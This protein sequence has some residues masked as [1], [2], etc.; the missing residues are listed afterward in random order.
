MQAVVGVFSAQ[1]EAEHAVDTL[2]STGISADS[3]TLLAPGDIRKEMES[4]PVDASES[5]GIGKAVGAVVGAAGGLTTGLV[6]AAII[7][8][9]GLVSALGLLG[10]AILTAVGGGV[11]GAAAAESIE[12][13]MTEGV[14]EDE[15]FVYED[16][17]RK[18][19]RVVIA[20]AEDEN[21][22]ARFRELLE[23][24]GA[25]SV[26]AARHKWWVGLRSAEEEHYSASGRKFGE[27]EKFYRLGFEAA[28][29]ARTR[30]MEFDQASSEMDSKLEDV[31]KQDP[32]KEAGEAFIRGYQR[33]RDYYQRICDE[34]KAA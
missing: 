33:G 29:H 5:P 11:V 26:D 31:Q 18:G 30:C 17:L 20:L 22:A 15:I 3:V 21:A 27:D 24:E 32:R 34:A 12:N 23:T 1:A 25:E 10:M 13:Q 19:R 8:G 4:V 16:A 7:P 28:L 6:V 9:V 14:P 2:R